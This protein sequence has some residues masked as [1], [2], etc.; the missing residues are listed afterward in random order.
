MVCGLDF[1]FICI[2]I[3]GKYRVFVVFYLKS[4]ERVSIG[5]NLKIYL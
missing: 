1:I 4:F 5:N 3:I 2:K